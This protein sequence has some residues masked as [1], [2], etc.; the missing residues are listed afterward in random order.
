MPGVLKSIRRFARVVCRGGAPGGPL[1]TLGAGFGLGIGVSLALG[2]APRFAV[3]AE[4][5]VESSGELRP[6]QSS[7]IRVDLVIENARIWSGDRI[8]FASFAAVRDGRFVHVGDVVPVRAAGDGVQR[9]DAGGRVVIPG[10]IDAHV[11]MLGGG[12]NLSQLGLRDATDRRDFVD[13]IR[14]WT[15]GLPDG[16]WVRGG[17]WSTESWANV[18]QPTREWIDEAAGD[19]PVYLPRM[20]GHSAL[21]NSAALRMAGI[22]ADSPPDPEGGRIDRDP[23]TGE[24]TGMLRESAMALVA[25]LLPE[26]TVDE[27]AAA[28]R[29]A[30][31][32]ANAHGIT[33]VGDI[34]P[35]P[36]ALPAYAALLAGD[37]SGVAPVTVRFHLYPTAFDW[38]AATAAVLAFEGD[39]DLAVV[40]GMKTYLDG[41][42]G[43]RTAFMREPFHCNPSGEEENRGLLREGIEGGQFERNLA[44]AAQAG[45]QTIA[46]AIGDEANHLLLDT[47]EASYSELSGARCRSEHAQHLLA[48]DIP[49]FGQLGVIASMQ[50]HHKADDGRYAED[51]IGEDRAETSYAFRSLLDAGAVLAFGSDWPVVTID[52]FA[53]VAAAV[54]GRTLDGDVWQPQESITVADALR[55]YMMGAAYSVKAEERI[56][57]I[58]PGLH[59][60]FVVL[61]ESPFGDAMGIDWTRV[62]PHETWMGGRRVYAAEAAEAP[63]AAEVTGGR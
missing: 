8:G 40:R 51:C 59:A 32:H 24:P 43:S 38:S 44:A 23:V 61:A 30:M 33:A 35:S 22:T 54:T 2:A 26:P 62:R 3:G 56:G 1:A 29:A 37:A 58:A 18:E 31:A 27:Q 4:A 11:H 41:S 6:S 63:E 42:L 9:V 20:D 36:D 47:L 12:A 28:L 49:R 21:V 16:A 57:R 50:P 39:E 5:S 60:D 19:H 14:A 13:R 25:A 10:L 15:A 45:L 17:R 48:E 52:P 53:G 7:P 46:H 55:G 34:P